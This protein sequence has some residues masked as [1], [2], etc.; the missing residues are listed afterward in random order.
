MVGSVRGNPPGRQEGDGESGPRTPAALRR[1]DRGGGLGRDR[2][3][4]RGRGPR[5]QRAHLLRRR[6]SL[7]PRDRRRARTRLGDRVRGRARRRAP[8]ARARL[9]VPAQRHPHA[10]RRRPAA[11]RVR[12][13]SRLAAPP[14]AVRAAEG[15]PR[16]RPR[17][18]RPLLAGRRRCCAPSARSG[19]VALLML[20]DQVYA[21]EVSPETLAFIRKRRDTRK[22][23]GEEVADF[24][25]YTRLYRESWEDP[26]IRWLLSTVSVS[27][28]I[29]DHDIHDDWNI[30]K[31]WVEEMRELDWWGERERAGLG[32]L[33]GL[34]VHRQPL[35]RA[36]ARERAARR[37]PR[38]RRRLG[39]PQRGRRGR[40]AVARR[41]PLELLPRLRRHPADRARLAHAGG[42][43]TRTAARSSTI[44]NGNGWRSI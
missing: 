29:D 38:R 15:G 28:V 22:P 9:G 5:P 36:T 17:V 43:S 3:A 40:A 7:R 20:G 16:G 18:R 8:L 32:D 4:V 13:L 31:A 14:R 24:E 25:E 10:R 11:A 27:M 6:P 37:R 35:A 44:R 30:S 33:L 23:P 21:D 2:R 39:D 42:R 12:L 34:P 26:E 1:R 41:R 19:R